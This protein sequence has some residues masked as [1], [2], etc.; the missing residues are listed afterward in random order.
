MCIY[1]HAQGNAHTCVQRHRNIIIYA[2]IHTYIYVCVNEHVRAHV[3]TG[4]CVRV[5]GHD[6]EGGLYS[7]S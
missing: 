1:K 5:S 7:A 4:M 2:H 6:L 3:R